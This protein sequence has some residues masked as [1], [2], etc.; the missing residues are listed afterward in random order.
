[1]LLY[2]GV[3]QGVFTWYFPLNTRFNRIDSPIAKEAPRPLFACRGEKGI[4]T[5]LQCLIMSVG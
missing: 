2:K 3:G 5:G 1:M 4:D